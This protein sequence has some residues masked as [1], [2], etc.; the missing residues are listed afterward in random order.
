MKSIVDDS[1]AKERLASLLLGGFGV[2]ALLLAVAGIYGVTSY[3]VTLRT[4]KIGLRMALGAQLRDIVVLV[5]RQGLMLADA[6]LI[7]GVGTALAL[8]R[9]L[10]SQLFGVSATGAG[11]FTMVPVILTWQR[12]WPATSQYGGDVGGSG[13]HSE[14]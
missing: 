5:L 11:I 2:I 1:V 3:T 4:K 14:V 8:T 13:T 9:V 12:W 10:A 6:G 7:L